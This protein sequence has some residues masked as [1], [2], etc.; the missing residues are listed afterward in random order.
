MIGGGQKWPYGFNYLAEQ[1]YERF[2]FGIGSLET[3]GHQSLRKRCHSDFILGLKDYLCSG[4]I[5][6][7]LFLLFCCF[8]FY[9]PNSFSR[10]FMF[11]LRSEMVFSSLFSFSCMRFIWNAICCWNS[12]NSSLLD[13]RSSESLSIVFILSTVSWEFILMKSM[14]SPRKLETPSRF[15]RGNP[16]YVISEGFCVAWASISRI[17]LEVNCV[18]AWSEGSWDDGGK[19]RRP[20]VVG[21]G[22]LFLSSFLPLFFPPAIIMSLSIWYGW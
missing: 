16:A 20:L 19:L 12:L 8:F 3:I 10:L 2:L 4:I 5:K 15:S 18:E 9:L 1:D 7:Y 21:L 14:T 13:L 6:M 11:S 17:P 22:G